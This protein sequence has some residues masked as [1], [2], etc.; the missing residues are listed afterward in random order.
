MFDGK[1]RFEHTSNGMRKRLTTLLAAAAL[2]LTGAGHAGPG[3]KTYQAFLENGGLYD[4]PLY[5]PAVGRRKW[6]YHRI[7]VA[8]RHSPAVEGLKELPGVHPGMSEH[9]FGNQCRD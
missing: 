6:R 1:G 2:V 7:R 3:E 4:E 8:G 9:V 5:R